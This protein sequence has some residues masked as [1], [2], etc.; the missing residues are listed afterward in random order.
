MR[1]ADDATR[2]DSLVAAW[3][4]MDERQRFVW[5]K[6]ITGEFRVGVSQSLV[7]RA[8]AEVSGV[9]A[10]VDG[11][12]PDGRLAADCRFRRA[13]SGARN[14]AT[15]TSAGPYP[16]CLAYPLE[17]AVEDLG[18]RR[19]AGGVE[20]G[21]HSRAVDPAAVANVS[22]VA[23]RGADHRSLPG[24]GGAGRAAAGRHG[25]RWRGAAVERRRAAAVRADAAAHRA[26]GAG[27][28]RSWRKC[29][30]CWWLTICWNSRARMCGSG[31][32]SGGARDWRQI[33]PP[34]RALVLSPLVQAASW[35]ELTQLREESRARKVEGFML[36]RRGSPYR[37]GRRRGDWWKWKID[38]YSV[39]AVLIYAQPGSGRRASLFTDYTFGVWDSGELVPF[40]KAYSGLT[41]EEIRQ[42]DA[43][44]RRNTRE[45][46][47]GARGEAGAGVRAG[48]R[49]HPAIAA[50]PV[51]HRRAFSAHGALAA[52]QEGGGSGYASRRSA[53]C[54]GRDRRHTAA[55][56]EA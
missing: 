2:R 37:V 43:F 41:D 32:S 23:R 1:D 24:A 16:F 36:K 21:R 17:G 4:E 49:G 29:R 11:A 5:N 25:D 31:R 42:V 12:P 7:V 44:V 13:D 22:L 3:R 53:R 20:V 39:D 34:D 47:A 14:R 30:W 9:D 48:V 51:G 19:M 10:E 6:L 45:V 33:A 56:R 40:A 46:R 35:E 15:P 27:R 38:P 8:L 55:I 50:A 52:R 18:D 28:R 54:W 26:K